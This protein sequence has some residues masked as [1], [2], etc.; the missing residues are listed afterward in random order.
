MLTGLQIALLARPWT[1]RVIIASVLS[2]FPASAQ[3]EPPAEPAPEAKPQTMTGHLPERRRL[4]A[5]GVKAL[6][7]YK[8]EAVANLSGGERARA[9]YAGQILIGAVLD[10]TRLGWFDGGSVRGSVTQ[11]HGREI[12]SVAGIDLLQQ[13]QEVFGRGNIWRLTELSVQ[14]SLLDGALVLKAG[15]M[16]MGEFAASD[17]EFSNLTFCGAAPGNLVGDYWLNWPL[18][19]WAGWA[20]L[21][22]GA[23]YV[24]AGVSEDNKRNLDEAFFLSRR[25]AR[26]ITGH[27][28]IGWTPVFGAQ[29]LP[30][31][32]VAGVWRSSD[33]A[34][35]VRPDQPDAHA[36]RGFYL[37]AQQQLTGQAS[38]NPATGLIDQRRGLNLFLNM[39][40][41]DRRTSML[42]SLINLGAFFHGPLRH[43][44]DDRIA[45]AI[46]W[47][48]SDP[49]S[50]NDYGD[51][52]PRAAEVVAEFYYGASLGPG[53]M[54]RPGLQFIRN[55]GG[56]SQAKD[57]AIFSTRLDLRL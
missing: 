7:E 32:F 44:P 56:L 17:C 13:P 49:P 3:T 38:L 41:A 29:A 28:E 50:V 31:R 51:A 52:L 53:A 2:A 10:T 36:R 33:K 15:R 24:K 48:R 9:A 26:G 57:S 37:Q 19:V 22:S 47:T 14:Q 4:E 16:P 40:F 55:P 30:G 21:R 5:S 12:G 11:R 18:A 23:V 6:I 35:S 1:H 34:V 42:T 8:G 27:G 45:V 39:A 46:G 43:R 54:L 20:K 25:G